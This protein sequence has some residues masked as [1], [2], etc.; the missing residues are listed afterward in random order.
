MSPEQ[1][2][3]TLASA[4]RIVLATVHEV[5]YPSVNPG[6]SVSI[7]FD[8]YPERTLVASFVSK[9]RTPAQ[10]IYE[11]FSE[12]TAVFALTDPVA[13]LPDGMSG[14]LTVTVASRPQAESLPVSVLGRRDG[15]S[16]VWVRAGESFRSVPVEVGLVGDARVEVR[17]GVRASD[18]VALEPELLPKAL[19][20]TER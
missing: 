17:S 18:D 13:E 3:L 7:A 8:A 16:V 4:E 9:S 12:Y 20:A 15:S 14:N 5:D 10:S 11:Q 19:R 2:V 1:R 6:Q